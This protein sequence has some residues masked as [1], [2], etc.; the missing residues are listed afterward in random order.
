MNECLK[1]RFLKNAIF[2]CN[3]HK[4]TPRDRQTCFFSSCKL[5]FGA[6]SR[7]MQTSHHLGSMFASC[8]RTNLLYW[9]MCQSA[10]L[11]KSPFFVLLSLPLYVADIAAA[12]S[13]PRC[14]TLVFASYG[15]VPCRNANLGRVCTDHGSRGSSAACDGV[16]SATSVGAETGLGTGAR[17][18]SR[19]G[20]LADA[21]VV[22][23][24]SLGL[25]TPN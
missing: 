9:R 19:C 16:G 15:V 21:L 7:M 25:S 22:P 5:S 8:V 13:M 14:R 11:S 6:A 18:S 3:I 10:P 17:P 20:R 2:C 4:P 12:S 24:L 1:N 23:T